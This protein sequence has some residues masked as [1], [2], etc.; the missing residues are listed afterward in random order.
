MHATGITIDSL[1]HIYVADYNGDGDTDVYVTTGA[2]NVLFD[3]HIG[4]LNHWLTV[5]LQGT[6]SNRSAIGARVRVV[7]GGV[8]QVNI[9][10]LITLSA[11]FM[12][13]QHVLLTDR[14]AQSSKDH[15]QLVL[16]IAIVH[17][18]AHTGG[19]VGAANAKAEAS[20]ALAEC[21]FN[22]L[23]VE[24]LKRGGVLLAAEIDHVAIGPQ[25]AVARAQQFVAQRVHHHR[26]P[27]Q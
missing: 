26:H 21:L 6:I 10:D 16:G 24:V 23:D 13:A 7:T 18:P 19:V 5:R 14:Y 20:S 12:Y 25:A 11:A 2:S 22:A 3:N 15:L 17:H 9:G 27:R 4:E 8:S 1:G